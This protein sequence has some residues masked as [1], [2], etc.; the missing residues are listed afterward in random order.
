M[1]LILVFFG[2]VFAA[3]GAIVANSRGKDPIQWAIICFFTGF[4]GLI[5]LAALGDGIKPTGITN[6]KWKALIDLD[7]EINLVAKHIRD[8]YGPHY[9]N[10]LAEKYLALGDKQYLKAA[11]QKVIL[12]AEEDIKNKPVPI[13]LGKSEF[14][15]FPDGSFTITKG[16][17]V[18][19]TFSNQRP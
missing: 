12:T 17:G 1:L 3:G 13:V 18:G 16:P 15:Q 10:M 8:K 5:V 6:P 11:A 4:I 19:M 7:D 14:K 9:E 2:A